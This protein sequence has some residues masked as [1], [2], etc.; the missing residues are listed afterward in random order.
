MIA[1]SV[2]IRLIWVGLINADGIVTY[3][4]GPWLT[5]HKQTNDFLLWNL[6]ARNYDRQRSPFETTVL[7]VVS[8]RYFHMHSISNKPV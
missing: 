1:I 4:L 6:N 2:H 7:S 3:I 5:S 8:G